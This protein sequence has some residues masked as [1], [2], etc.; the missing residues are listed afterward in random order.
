MENKINLR[1]AILFA[2]AFLLFSC[3]DLKNPK[4]RNKLVF[5]DSRN[6]VV[7]SINVMNE[8]LLRTNKENYIYAVDS[9]QL[10]INDYTQY[11]QKVGLIT[12][13]LLFKSKWLTFI[14][15]LER[16]RFVNLAMYLN[17]NYLS[18]YDIENGQPVYLYRADIYMADRQADIERVVVLVNSEKDINLNRYK[19]LNSFENLF[20]LANKDAK[21]WESN[22]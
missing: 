16:K 15:T 21:I 5:I 14:D 18:R 2:A 6:A 8:I 13:S 3:K 1:L 4:G 11:A 7:D 9:Y 22:D 17:K 10:Y 12:D 19:I 20:L